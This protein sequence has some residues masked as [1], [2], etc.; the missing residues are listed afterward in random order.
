MNKTDAMRYL[1]SL[2][3][4]YEIIE[5][6]IVDGE[7][8]DD[9]EYPKELVYKTLVTKGKEV[10]VVMIPLNE[11]V[12][13]KKLGNLVG[14]KVSMVSVNDL[15]DLTGYV[16]GCCCPFAMTKKYP[17][18]VQEGILLK[19]FIVISGGR[20]DVDIKISSKDLIKATDAKIVD[21]I[22]KV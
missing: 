8:V 12:D 11:K 1:D 7:I 16:R 13:F 20:M 6:D 4:S 17:I 15:F 5:Y 18:Y 9:L 19:D 22:K 3:I 14:E 21:V 2:N 10:F